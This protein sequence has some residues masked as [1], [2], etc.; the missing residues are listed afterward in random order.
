MLTYG[1]AND[2]S[3]PTELDDLGDIAS[4]SGAGRIAWNGGDADVLLDGGEFGGMVSSLKPSFHAG[5]DG[6]WNMSWPVSSA[7]FAVCGQ[8]FMQNMAYE[9]TGN[10][11]F[12]CINLFS[13]T[14]KYASLIAEGSSAASAS[15][16][17]FRPYPIVLLIFS[18]T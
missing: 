2:L 6:T 9:I 12:A 5:G 17:S 14:I 3:V 1:R 11:R 15:W 8:S 16:T 7:R 18:V 10:S 4:I 13:L